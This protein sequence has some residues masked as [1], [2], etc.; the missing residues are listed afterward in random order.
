MPAIE[1]NNVA[2]QKSL[3]ELLPPWILAFTGII[4]AAG[5][6]VVLVF[7]DRFGIR[8][9]G[10]E[11]WKARY[12]H[13][14][15]LC[16]SFPLILNGTILSIVYLVLDGAYEKSIMLPRLLPIGLL[17]TNLE[18]TCFFMIMFTNRSS[19]GSSIAGLSPLGWILAVT[20]LGLPILLLVERIMEGLVPKF[21]RREAEAK[22]VNQSYSVIT[23]WILTLIVACLDVWYF[24]D[25]KDTVTGMQPS[26]AIA[27][28]GFSIILGI[29]FSTVTIYE[30]RQPKEN[31]K[32]AISVLL[33]AVAGPFLYLVVL[34]FS[35]GVYQNIPSTRGGGDYTMAPKVTVTMKVTPTITRSDMKYFS[36]ID[37]K[38]TIPLILIEETSW[39]LYLA[40]PNEAGGPAE[41]KAIGGRK[42]EIAI[43]NK[44]EV[45]KI[46]S[47]SRNPKKHQ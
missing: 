39:A 32:K 13:I 26:L 23:R 30:R 33:S 21:H 24:F 35:Y 9:A 42:P 2:R 43:I 4:Y 34:S 37:P 14:G 20:L 1:R 6:L 46:H 12:I 31:R 41:W 17:L 7:L 10:A 22:P 3:T 27:Y 36:T 15:I 16:L 40:D 18:I 8:E 19:E 47:E 25:F 5:F 45:L 11:F 28:I 38:V 29:V 44:S